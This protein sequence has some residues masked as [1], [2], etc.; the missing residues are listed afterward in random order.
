MPPAKPSFVFVM[1]GNCT[2]MHQQQHCNYLFCT[3]SFRTSCQ[4]ILHSDRGMHPRGTQLRV[5]YWTTVLYYTVYFFLKRK[6]FFIFFSYTVQIRKG[7]PG[8]VL[9]LT[10]PTVEI[11]DLTATLFTYVMLRIV[12]LPHSTAARNLPDSTTTSKPT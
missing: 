1:T 4:C 5:P 6:E 8:V 10:I 2:R 9:L 7:G 3:A 11:L 12:N